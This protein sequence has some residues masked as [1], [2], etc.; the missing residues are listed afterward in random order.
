MEG[1]AQSYSCDTVRLVNRKSQLTPCVSHI[2]INSRKGVCIRIGR[3]ARLTVMNHD[4]A[5][6]GLA[7]AS[8]TGG[9]AR[10]VF[11][12]PVSAKPNFQCRYFRFHRRFP[13][14]VQERNMCLGSDVALNIFVRS[15]LLAVLFH[16]I[17]RDSQQTLDIVLCRFTDLDFFDNILVRRANISRICRACS[18]EGR[19]ENSEEKKFNSFHGSL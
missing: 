12:D 5:L 15:N 7:N 16:D 14:N 18:Q 6:V 9:L 10:D 11:H 4:V 2:P 1:Q 8:I 17:C 3:S 13:R 19:K